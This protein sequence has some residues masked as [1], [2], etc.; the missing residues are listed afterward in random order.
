MEDS[1]PVGSHCCE[2]QPDMQCPVYPK[3]IGA[4]WPSF[5]CRIRLI[6]HH[7]SFDIVASD[8]IKMGG[9]RIHSTGEGEQMNKEKE[10]AVESLRKFGLYQDYTTFYMEQSKQKLILTSDSA[11]VELR[12]Y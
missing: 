1:F 2:A 12:R 9:F 6:E 7:K 3:L 11:L 10:V 5:E 8:S 4:H